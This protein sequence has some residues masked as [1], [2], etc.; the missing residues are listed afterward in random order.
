M[1][2]CKLDFFYQNKLNCNYFIK[3]KYE[4]NCI[5]LKKKIKI[6]L[7]FFL[8]LVC[9]LKSP[10][11]KKAAKPEIAKKINIFTEI[12]TAAKNLTNINWPK[13]WDLFSI[14]LVVDFV[15]NIFQFTWG[16][17]LTETYGLAPKHMSYIFATM[18]VLSI[19]VAVNME[20][21]K[22]LIYKN[23]N[24]SG[25]SRLLHVIILFT[26]SY[27][28]FGL[29]TSLTPFVLFLIPLVLGRS[30]YESTITEMLLFRASPEEKGS[31]M[32]AFDN[33]MALGGLVAPITSGIISSVVGDSG[34]FISCTI[35]LVLGGIIVH[36]SSRRAIKSE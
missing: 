14:K 20:R 7:Y 17:I 23:D 19:G 15:L 13:Y 21:I 24:N 4:K 9:L 30:L 33:T 26:I 35:P 10:T 2:A 8:G 28:G 27:I 29:S 22:K 31:V 36:R 34:T 25:F 6:Y 3:Q 12:K 32:G 1:Y 16:I 18:M 5:L 11:V